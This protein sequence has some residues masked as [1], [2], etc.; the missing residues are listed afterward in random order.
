M[1]ADKG[2]YFK[3]KA[4]FPLTDRKVQARILHTLTACGRKKHKKIAV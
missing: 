2:N 3:I 4:D 1:I